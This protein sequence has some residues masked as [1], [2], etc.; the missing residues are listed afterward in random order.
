MLSTGIWPRHAL[1]GAG[2][3]HRFMSSSRRR[4]VHHWLTPA[5]FMVGGYVALVIVAALYPP[6][7]G[8]GP[9]PWPAVVVG[10]AGA[11]A[12]RW[13]VAAAGARYGNVHLVRVSRLHWYGRRGCRAWCQPYWPDLPAHSS[14]FSAVLGGRGVREGRW[15][16]VTG[17]IGGGSYGDSRV[18]YVSGVL[19]ALPARAPRAATRIGSGRRPR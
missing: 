18:L 10:F 12:R 13:E 5:L 3:E 6:E 2:C 17:E 16:Y 8:G 15:M 14:W 4:L 11:L 1:V 19:D 9:G 7:E